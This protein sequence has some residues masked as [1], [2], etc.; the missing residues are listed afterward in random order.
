[1]LACEPLIGLVAVCAVQ[2][3]YVFLHGVVL[4]LSLVL[5]CLP[6]LRWGGHDSLFF[7]FNSLFLFRV[8]PFNSCLNVYVVPVVSSTM[9]WRVCVGS[10]LLTYEYC[11]LVTK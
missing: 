7:F 1:M 2:P 9:A 8:L 10:T 11:T 3:A 5:Y 6:H 4:F